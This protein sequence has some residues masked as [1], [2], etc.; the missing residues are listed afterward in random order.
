[1][2][3]SDSSQYTAMV[4]QLWVRSV[5]ALTTKVH[6][7]AI[8]PQREQLCYNQHAMENEQRRSCVALLR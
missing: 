8:G 5:S 1:M 7:I 6:I 4:F 2:D 3:K